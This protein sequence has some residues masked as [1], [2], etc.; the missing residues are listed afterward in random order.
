MG[1]ILSS[2]KENL[3]I[4]NLI[5][6]A[7]LHVELTLT[8]QLGEKFFRSITKIRKD[9]FTNK[10]IQAGL[11]FVFI[12]EKL[13]SRCIISDNSLVYTERR[14]FDHVR[15]QEIS[16]VLGKEFIKAFELGEDNFRILGKIYRYTLEVP[17][18]F[19]NF[20]EAVSFFK[21]DD[22][23]RL[24]L[25]TLFKEKGN[26]IHLEI[27]SVDVDNNLVEDSLAINC[28]INNADQ[29][30]SHK[31]NALDGILTFADNYNDQRLPELLSQKLGL[32]N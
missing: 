27:G 4:K 6:G 25:R 16:R 21:G 9:L 28:D 8:P 17:G 1:S 18:I 19:N 29:D 26:N 32:K 13:K 24:F 11:P 30:S 7:H 2:I 31:L 14:N 20:K 22:I 3:K 15:F 10:I 12:H 5:F 23:E